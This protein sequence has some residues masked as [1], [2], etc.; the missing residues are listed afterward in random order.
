MEY[1]FLAWVEANE[2]PFVAIFCAMI[3]LA[4]FTMFAFAAA[5][6]ALVSVYR[7]ISK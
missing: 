4:F 2:V 7:K 1:A 6:D 3:G 5:L